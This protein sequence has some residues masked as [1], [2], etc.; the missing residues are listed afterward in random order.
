M[1]A[2][3]ICEISQSYQTV[4]LTIKKETMNEYELNPFVITQKITDDICL[5]TNFV[6]G[7]HI[8]LKS[9]IANIIYNQEKCLSSLSETHPD[10]FRRLLDGQFIIRENSEEYRERII[11]QMNSSRNDS[12][13]YHVIVNP[14]LD[15]NLDCWYCYENKIPGSAMSTEVTDAVCKNIK[16][17]YDS[18]P[19]KVLKV[20]FFGGEPFLRPMAIQRIVEFCRNFCLLNTVSLILDFTTNGTLITR[21][22]LD[23]IR[24]CT[25]MFQIT[26]DGNKEQH[27]R[28]KKPRYGDP[29][30][31]AMTINNIHRIQE[32]IQNSFVAVRINFDGE[33]LNRFD[34]ILEKLDD[35]DR[36]R[37][38]I[39]LKKVWQ[40]DSESIS[41]DIV[42]RCIDKILDR[43]FILDYYS[44]GGVCFADRRNQITINFD[45]NI[46]K[47]TT[48]KR[49][50]N[51]NALGKLDCNNGNVI[52]DESKIAYLSNEGIPSGCHTC[53]MF[54]SCGG[55]CRKKTPGWKDEDCFL[56]SQRMSMEEYALIQFKAEMTKRGIIRAGATTA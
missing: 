43:N 46:Y 14:T 44:Q 19:Y 50:D 4:G 28:I 26:L 45:G 9:G 18:N 32:T 49:F 48:I 12:E 11:K 31:F 7:S 51:D 20:S 5:L 21:T 3:K 42:N 53:Q 40:I 36:K 6:D 34:E 39:I 52:W 10:I 33:T 16:T 38:K 27:N 41:P 17:H 15:C 30:S 56:K 29:D 55:P 25:C 1:I 24:E 13:L 54:P 8:F 35:L 37:T 23:T 2:A 47:C 22:V